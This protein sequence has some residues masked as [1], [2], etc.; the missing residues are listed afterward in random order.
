[1]KSQKILFLALGLLILVVAL[2]AF[3]SRDRAAVQSFPATVHRDCAPWDGAAFTIQVPLQDGD[4]IHISIWQSPDIVFPKTFSFP[5]DTG[6]IGNA[7][8]I[9]ALGL[10]DTLSGE[11]T[12]QRVQAGIPIEGRFSLGS[13]GGGQFEAQFRAEWDEEV[14]MCG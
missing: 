10:P 9:H 8:L 7:I 14:V 12:L 2:F 5:D 4:S 6:Q 1:M 3:L 13:A 11:V